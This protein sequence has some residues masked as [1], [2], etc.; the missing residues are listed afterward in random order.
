MDAGRTAPSKH[1]GEDD[2]GGRQGHGRRYDQRRSASGERRGNA[3]GQPEK[4]K[5]RQGEGET[6]VRDRGARRH[7]KA[8]EK[9]RGGGE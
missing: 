7:G 6:I 9:R 5:T 4:G 2:H 3:K 8:V 1:G